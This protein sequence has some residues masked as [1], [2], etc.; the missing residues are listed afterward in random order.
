MRL[1]GEGDRHARA[2]Q[3]LAERAELSQVDL[4]VH[5]R[6]VR[7]AAERGGDCPPRGPL[8]CQ[9]RVDADGAS[10]ARHE[11]CEIEARRDQGEGEAGWHGGGVEGRAA[12]QG[13]AG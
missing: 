4:A 7:L 11:G 13:A 3:R 5:R 9:V 2:V 6:H 8:P 12:L 1:S 10:R